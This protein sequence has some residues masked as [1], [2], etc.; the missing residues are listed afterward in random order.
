VKRYGHKT[1]RDRHDFFLSFI[2]YPSEISRSCLS[3]VAILGP[4]PPFSSSARCYLLPTFLPPPSFLPCSISTLT[5][6]GQSIRTPSS[7]GAANQSAPFPCVGPRLWR[8]WPRGGAAHILLTC[9]VRKCKYASFSSI[10]ISTIGPVY[11]KKSTEFCSFPVS[12]IFKTT[13]FSRKFFRHSIS[14][15]HQQTQHF[16]N[17]LPSNSNW[18]KRIQNSIFLTIVKSVFL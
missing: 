10:F 2:S 16:I 4:P 14:Q 12:N 17:W 13:W 11:K 6:T 1:C 18:Q 15:W 5:A 3:P 9:N 8:Q 7:Y